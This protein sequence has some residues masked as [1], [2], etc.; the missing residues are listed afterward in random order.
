MARKRPRNIQQ[1]FS[2]QRF[3]RFTD[4]THQ[5]QHWQQ[6]LQ[7]CLAGLGLTPLSQHCTVVS[8]RA[9]TLIIE[10]PSAAIANRLKLQQQRIITHFQDESTG[11]ITQLEV[12]I[13]PTSN[14][15]SEQAVSIDKTPPPKAAAEEVS[16]VTQLREQAARCEEPLRS[17][18]LALADKYEQE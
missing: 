12:R 9:H 4:F 15:A 8:V 3:Q 17:Q 16:V 10:V 5:Y 6:Q 1:L 2:S 14:D 11:Q 18:L 7:Q 13:R